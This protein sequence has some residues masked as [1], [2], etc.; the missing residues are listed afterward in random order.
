MKI[1]APCLI[2]GK[3]IPFLRSFSTYCTAN[4]FE[5]G[6]QWYFTRN[7]AEHNFHTEARAFSVWLDQKDFAML[8]RKA[9]E[10]MTPPADQLHSNYYY[11]FYRSVLKCQRDT[12]PQV[13]SWNAASSSNCLCMVLSSGWFFKITESV[14]R[15]SKSWSKVY[16][17]GEW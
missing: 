5:K 17:T 3:T 16:I 9:F 14:R 4:S 2:S 7:G 6:V 8:T 10:K 13:F 1:Y 12:E 11:R 15:P